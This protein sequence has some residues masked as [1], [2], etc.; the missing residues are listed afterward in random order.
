MNSFL[1]PKF[2]EVIQNKFTDASPEDLDFDIPMHW[3]EQDLQNFLLWCAGLKVSDIVFKSNEFVYVRLDGR[4][5]AVTKT[6]IAQ[7][8]MEVL[9]ESS[10]KSNS[11][12]ASVISGVPLDFSYSVRAGRGLNTRFRSNATAISSGGSNVGVSITFRVIAGVPP[13]LSDFDIEQGILDEIFIDKGLV[14]ATGVMGSGKSTLIASVLHK[15]IKDEEINVLTYEDPIEFDYGEIQGRKAIVQQTEVPTHL[16]E[17]FDGAVTNSTRRAA[18]VILMGESRNRETFIKMLEQSQ[19]GSAVYST[20]HT[21]T[22]ASTLPRIIN[23]YPSE[24]Q[25]QIA[26]MIISS[27]RLIVQQRLLPRQDGK[28]R[29]PL[30]EF[31]AFTPEMKRTLLETPISA[32][33][34]V[35]Q[36]MVNKHGQSLMKDATDKYEK[37]LIRE[38][39]YL[40]IKKELN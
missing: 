4:W 33:E 26:S 40:K 29:I 38:S 27:I 2:I 24:E 11:T 10:S 13:S 25:N 30:R 5:L 19:I 37:A 22:V 6:K 8:D 23:T 15:R 9:I 1:N 32:L 18:D 3:H 31:L 35:I 39:D 7:S 17:G 20:V 16:R 28:G 21:N 12:Y 14:L 36:E 34:K